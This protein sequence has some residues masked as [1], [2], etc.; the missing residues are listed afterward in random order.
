MILQEMVLVPEQL[1]GKSLDWERTIHRPHPCHHHR[2][3]KSTRRT[4][5][6][7]QALRLQG[8]GQR[9][10]LKRLRVLPQCELSLPLEVG[11]AWLPHRRGGVFRLPRRLSSLP[12]RY[13]NVR[14]RK[15]KDKT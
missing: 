8:L 5:I 14:R 2:R 7:E 3:H 11:G 4:L 6:D 9:R 13:A 15:E 1:V 12:R 10:L